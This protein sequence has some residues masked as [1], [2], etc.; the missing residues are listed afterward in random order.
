MKEGVSSRRRTKSARLPAPKLGIVGEC[1]RTV[2]RGHSQH[3]GRHHPMVEVRA[4]L[5][6]NQRRQSESVELFCPSFDAAPSEPNANCTPLESKS[7]TG[8]SPLPREIAGRIVHWRRAAFGEKVE[9][10]SL[11]PDR[12][13]H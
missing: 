1:A 10:R 13:R 2:A 6:V 12:M 4:G 7:R 9:V 5:V 8:A 11:D 3:L